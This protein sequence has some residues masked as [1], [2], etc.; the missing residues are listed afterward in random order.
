M[1]T[2]GRFAVQSL[3]ATIIFNAILLGIIYS[4]VGDALQA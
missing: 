2:K 3:I 1:N 4:L